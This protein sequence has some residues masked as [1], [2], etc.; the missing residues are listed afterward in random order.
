MP[1]SLTPPA[2]HDLTDDDLEEILAY[3]R[4]LAITTPGTLAVAAHPARELVNI[5]DADPDGIAPEVA[6]RLTEGLE[7][8]AS[9]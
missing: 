2:D 4:T 9:V 5:I 6:R 1:D 8:L 7:I 3:R